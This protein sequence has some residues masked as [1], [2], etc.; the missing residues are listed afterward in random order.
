MNSSYFFVSDICVSA[1]FRY[2]T[3]KPL[4]DIEGGQVLE[5][6]LLGG[7]MTAILQNL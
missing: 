1:V 6:M 5:M 7:Q 4:V 2:H 3:G